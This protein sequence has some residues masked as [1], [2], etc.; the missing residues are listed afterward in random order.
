M[1][2]QEAHTRLSRWLHTRAISQELNICVSPEMKKLKDMEPWFLHLILYIWVKPRALN[3][4]VVQMLR[5]L[6]YVLM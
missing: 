2:P 5:T 1:Q 3:S 4:S 6:M